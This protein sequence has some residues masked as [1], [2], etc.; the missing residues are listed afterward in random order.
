MSD[1]TTN[2][3]S[4]DVFARDPD[5][6]FAETRMSFGDHIEEL[7]RYLW[8]AIA[9]LGFCLVIGF[10][11]DGIGYATEWP[12]YPGART[13]H[14]RVAYWTARFKG[15]PI[16][17]GDKLKFGI[18]V[19]LMQIIQD[20]VEEE[21]TNF[22]ERQQQK[23]MKDL[24]Q[25]GTLAAEANEP[26]P[27]KQIYPKRTLALL[28]GVAE[29]QVEIPEK[30]RK[31][32]PKETVAQMLGVEVDKL[33]EEYQ[34]GTEGLEAP[35][36][37]L[38]VETE[39]ALVQGRNVIRPRTLTTLSVQEAL[40][41]YF[42]VCL[43]AG[44]V[45]ASPWVFWQIW[46][47]VA[48]GLYPHEKRLV[49]VYLPFSLGL[50]LS[51]VFVCQFLVMP[52]AVSAMLW[53]NEWLGMTPDLRLNEWLSFAIWMPVIFGLSF[54]TPLVMLFVG[55]L[56]IADVPFFAAKRKYAYFAMCVF[57]A[58]I[59]PSPDAITMLML[60]L[61]MCGLYELG[62]I[63]IKMQPKPEFSDEE[64]ETDELVEV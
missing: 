43:V 50:F 56:G 52:Q 10:I 18:G 39:N 58:F 4:D 60:A 14:L 57:S 54:Q 59:T 42:K 49:H 32:I 53:F 13:G 44:L 64:L 25:S 31:H 3:I 38:P 33:P 5:D 30:Q 15:K 26:K 22:A 62:I 51:G 34:N 41:V 23:A 19:P 1:P 27:I 16:S 28:R 35:V 9:G 37:I 6:F 24:N 8:K 12:L 63:L 48:A 47:F 40:V 55:K 61:P 29:D 46:A 11:L 21:L 20:P 7:R 36:F 2:G 17:A 45:I